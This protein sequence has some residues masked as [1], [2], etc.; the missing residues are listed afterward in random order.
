MAELGYERTTMETIS[1][2]AGVSKGAITH[3]FGRAMQF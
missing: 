2:R 3:Q 1:K